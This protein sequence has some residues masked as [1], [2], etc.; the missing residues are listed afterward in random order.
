MTVILPD[1]QIDGVETEVAKF[2][3]RRSH[4]HLLTSDH[5]SYCGFL[6]WPSGLLPASSKDV[7]P[8]RT[9]LAAHGLRRPWTAWPTTLGRPLGERPVG[10]CLVRGLRLTPS[11]RTT[12]AHDVR[13]TSAANTRCLRLC[14]PAVVRPP[15]LYVLL[16][17]ADC[18]S[19]GSSAKL[20]PDQ[21][22]TGGVG[23][24][25]PKPTSDVA[26]HYSYSV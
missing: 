19:Q 17:G 12:G 18:E 3:F 9:G 2:G 24:F 13:T 21:L 15:L 22:S 11:M 8:A 10:P 6:S 5:G 16:Y 20:P 25:V 4:L 1:R 7:E 23:L 26:Y 14:T